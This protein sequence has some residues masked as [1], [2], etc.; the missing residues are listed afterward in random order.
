[1][2]SYKSVS[3][4]SVFCQ[5]RLNASCRRYFVPI[6]LK[7]SKNKTAQETIHGCVVVT[8]NQIHNSTITKNTRKIIKYI[9]IRYITKNLFW[10]KDRIR[11]VMKKWHCNTEK[12]WMSAYKSIQAIIDSLFVLFNWAIVVFNVNKGSLC[13]RA[14]RASVWESRQNSQLVLK[15]SKYSA[16]SSLFSLKNVNF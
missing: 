1:M 2:K 4:L 6:V 7:K 8:V 3:P 16:S 10:N 13:S 5:S 14:P 12:W 15:T 9:M 11:S